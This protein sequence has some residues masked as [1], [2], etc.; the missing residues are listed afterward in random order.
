IIR[1]RGPI[2]WAG[3]LA[4]ASGLGVARPWG[5]TM[6]AHSVRRRMSFMVVVFKSRSVCMVRIHLR[7]GALHEPDYVL[8]RVLHAGQLALEQGDAFIGLPGAL[9]QGQ[10]S[11]EHTSE[12]QSLTNLVCRLLLE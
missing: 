2:F 1:S 7:S 10:R 4:A 9:Q 6:G 3:R 5:C 12:L 11:E 8:D